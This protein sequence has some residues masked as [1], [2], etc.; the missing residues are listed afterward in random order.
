M[1]LTANQTNYGQMKVANITIDQLKHGYKIMVQKFIQDNSDG[2]SIVTERYIR[3]LQTEI[4][5]Y[6]IAVAKNVYVDNLVQLDGIV[7]KYNNTYQNAVKMKPVHV[8]SST[9]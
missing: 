2:K 8:N 7:D 9:I 6:M 4:Y 3:T 5:K 1:Y